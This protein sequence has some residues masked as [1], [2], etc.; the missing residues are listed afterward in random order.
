MNVHSITTST[1]L[2]FASF[3]GGCVTATK[4]MS[5]PDVSTL[6]AQPALPDPLVMLDG[7]RI[8][9]RAQWLNE[10][11]PE[12]QA[13]FQHYMYGPIPPKPA[14]MQVKVLAEH[15]DFLGGSATLRLVSLETGLTN[16]PRIDL[17]LVVPNERRAPAPVFLA[18]NFCG[19]HALTDDPRVPLARGWLYSSCKGCTNNAATEAARGA[20]AADWPLAEIVR[21]GYALASF[22]SGDIDSD[23]KEVSD[24]IYAWLAA[25]NAEKNNPAN[26]GSIAAWAWGFHRCVDY[27]VTDHD[28]DSG[29]IAAVGHSRNGK[30][31]LLATAFDERIA[32][33][34]PHQAGCGGTA[35][36]RGKTGESVRQINNGFPHWFNAE[37]KKFNDAPERLPFDQ[38]CLVALCAPRPVLFS[39]AQE[40]QWANPSGQFD[41]LKAADPVYRLLGVE[42][43]TAKEMPPQRQLVDSRLGYYIREGKHSM[44]ADDWQVF[45]N[46]ADRHWHKPA[47]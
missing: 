11:R 37:F 36:S 34:F 42:G 25:G 13:L 29:H 20:Q 44:T 7:S 19:N 4:P 17:M 16:A 15:R 8:A 22:Y 39:N 47:P 14:R 3:L 23:R 41:V 32:M 27:L 1:V 5:F 18:M 21:R 35:P 38:H 40:D 31:A 45:L 6:P 43:L 9:S 2:L 26:R 33:A 30:T 46:F 28:V 10:R 24:G 12:L